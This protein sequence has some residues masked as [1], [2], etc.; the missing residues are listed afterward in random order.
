M[1]LAENS[2]LETCRQL[3]KRFQYALKE[4]PLIESFEIHWH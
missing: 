1:P 3:E 2:D 4:D